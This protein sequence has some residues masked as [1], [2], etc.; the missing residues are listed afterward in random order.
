MKC[1]QRFNI[2][3][4]TYFL[5]ICKNRSTILNFVCVHY[6][7]W[8]SYR[9]PPG[10]PRCTIF[11]DSYFQTF[12]GN[13]FCGSRIDQLDALLF[14]GKKCCEFNFRGRCQSVITAKLCT[15]KIWCY[16]V[17]IIEQFDLGVCKHK[18]FDY[19]INT[20]PAVVHY[21]VT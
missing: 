15:W 6:V 16:T 8:K 17:N 1:L 18:T 11:V 3:K 19:A 4:I 2:Y 21:Y 9:T 10:I 7:L 13:R 5:W 14:Q 20:W 12:R